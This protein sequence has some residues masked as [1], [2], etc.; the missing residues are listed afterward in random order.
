MGGARAL[1]YRGSFPHSAA[2][3]IEFIHYRKRAARRRGR[4]SP[5][6][7]EVAPTSNAASATA[8]SFLVGV[9]PVTRAPSKMNGHID[10]HAGMRIL[11]D[12]I[13]Q[14]D[15]LKAKVSAS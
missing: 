7:G 14:P 15:C 12:A 6:C 11:A 13:T 10:A 9:F 5:T 1:R 8:P 4:R 3:V 2:A